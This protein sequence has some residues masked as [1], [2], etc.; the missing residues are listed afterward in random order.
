MQQKEY[1]GQQVKQLLLVTNY[2][3]LKIIVINLLLEATIVM[4]VVCLE[5]QTVLLILKKTSIFIDPQKVIATM[6]KRLHFQL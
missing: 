5:Q 2:A 4:N 1:L 3:M 6:L